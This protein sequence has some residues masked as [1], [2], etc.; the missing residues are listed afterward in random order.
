M[1]NAYCM[2]TMAEAYGPYIDEWMSSKINNGDKFSIIDK[3]NNT[4]FDKGFGF[5]DAEL[6]DK[7]YRNQE[8]S[9]FHSWNPGGGRTVA[10]FYAHFRMINFYLSYPDYDY[11][12]FFDDD[13]A[14]NN[15]EAFFDSFNSESSDFL[16]YFCFKNKGVLSQPSVPEI[17]DK[18]RSSYGWFG[19]FPGD[20]D[21]MPPDVGDLFGSFFP[22][23]RFS[24]SALKNILEITNNG[25]NGY[26]EGFVPTVLNHNGFKLNTIIKSDDTSDFFNVDELNILHKH[27]RVTWAWI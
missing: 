5:T 12:W 13:V 19:R 10:W 11:Y 3:T 15:W 16:S 8:I 6:R 1:N 27:I 4:G 17:N 9:K 21:K 26:H 22:T 20:G 23:T 25:Y 18:S 14:M 2:C 7:F 24:N